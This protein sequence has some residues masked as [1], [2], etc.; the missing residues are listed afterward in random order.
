[1]RRMQLALNLDAYVAVLRFDDLVGHHLHF[2]G[3]F[4]VLPTH[5]SLDGKNG[6]LRIGHRLPFGDLADETLTALSEPD[7]GRRQAASFRVDDDLR[8]IALHDGDNGVC[9]AEV[10]ANNL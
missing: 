6:V 8:L 10:N 4:L 3:D 5:E 2:F 7:D 9:G 1:M